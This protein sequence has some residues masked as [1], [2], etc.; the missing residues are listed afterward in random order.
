MR[1]EQVR[2]PVAVTVPGGVQDAAVFGGLVLPAGD[3]GRE[4]GIVPPGGRA[5]QGGLI[6]QVI[7][8]AD[9]QGIAASGVQLVVKSRLA[10][11]RSAWS[12]DASARSR[13]SWA[14]HQ[15]WFATTA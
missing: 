5:D 9:Q 14:W 15:P 3:H 8:H 6:A 4:R 12:A 10:R 2:G 7:E 11:L 1:G 13:A